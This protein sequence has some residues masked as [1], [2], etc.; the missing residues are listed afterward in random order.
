[1][2][3][4][5]K[6][7]ITNYDNKK[8]YVPYLGLEKDKRALLSLSFENKND[9]EL[10]RKDS[11]F[12]FYLSAD[13]PILTINGLSIKQITNTDLVKPQIDIEIQ[14]TNYGETTINIEDGDKNI[15]GRLD[16]ICHEIQYRKLHLVFV[17]F[18]DSNVWQSLNPK[19]FENY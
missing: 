2:Y 19:N 17:N 11:N 9:Y 14:A 8:H 15:Y 3:S 7:F 18:Q 5:Y 10:A 16:F 6:S 1:M 13:L 12:V 4:M